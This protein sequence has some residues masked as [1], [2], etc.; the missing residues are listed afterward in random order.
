MAKARIYRWVQGSPMLAGVPVQLLL[1]LL[2]CAC[3]AGFGGMAVSTWVGAALLLGLGG[4]YGALALCYRQD[5]A[6][7]LGACLRLRVRFNPEVSS[8]A[9]SRKAVRFE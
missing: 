4:I 3:I 6:A 5:P 8:Y 9:R 7:V 2:G 1:G